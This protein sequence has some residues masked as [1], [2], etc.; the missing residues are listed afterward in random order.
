M[1]RSLRSTLIAV[2]LAAAEAA[3]LPDLIPQVDRISIEHDQTVSQGDVTEGC[4]GATSGRTLLRFGVRFFNAGEDTLTIG[5]PQCPDCETNPGALCD[6]TRFV[7][8]PA[9]GHNHPHYDGFAHYQLLAMDERTVVAVGAKVSFCIRET[10]CPEGTPVIHTCENQGI[11]PG[12]YDYYDPTLGCQYV[13]VTDVPDIERRSFILRV[14]LDP[15]DTLPDADP[16]NNALD[17]IVPGC[18]DGIVD[19]EEACD[20]TP[21]CN[22]DCTPRAEGSVCRPSQHGCDEPEACDGAGGECPADAPAAPG[23]GI[24]GQCVPEGT[25]SDD[26]CGMC[27]PDAA[28]DAWTPRFLPDAPG[29][30]CR[31]RA[32]DAERE[33]CKRKA[34]R[35]LRRRLGR[36]E[37]LLAKLEERGGESDGERFMRAVERLGV[38]TARRGCAEAGAAALAEQ[39]AMYLGSR[40]EPL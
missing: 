34:S 28:S 15:D 8:S 4:A 33:V 22:D 11:Q 36:V 10:A 23:C 7:C 32:I 20:G 27:E 12:C 3:A 1:G 26:G 18:G 40:V 6:D 39:A 29:I 19:G 25:I 17:T 13:D 30:R 24:G 21:C 14:T 38:F 9:D 35:Q 31:L 37:R 16:T 5:D 2:V